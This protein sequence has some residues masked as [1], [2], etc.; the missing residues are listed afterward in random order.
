ME[1]YERPASTR[2][3]ECG[4]LSMYGRGLRKVVFCAVRD[5]KKMPRI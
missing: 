2:E 3:R 5:E 1:G 4:S